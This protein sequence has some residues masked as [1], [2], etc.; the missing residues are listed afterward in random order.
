MKGKGTFTEI[1]NKTHNE[2]IR[3]NDKGTGIGNILEWVDCDEPP[4][5]CIKYHNYDDLCYKI[6][7]KHISNI[8]LNF[9]NEKSQPL[10][11][12]N[13]LIHLQIKKLQKKSYY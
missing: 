6:E 4:F 12:D 3:G 8:R 9:Y 2:I 5:T 7:N 10:I 13:A 11:L 1:S